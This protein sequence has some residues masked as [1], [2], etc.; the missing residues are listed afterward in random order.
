[1]KHISRLVLATR[2]EHKIEEIRQ[3]LGSGIDYRTLDQYGALQIKEAG[4]TLYENSLAKALYAHKVTGTPALADDSGLFIDAL[5]GDPGVYSA[6]YGATDEQ[7]ISR[8][9]KNIRSQENRRASFRAVFVL[10][11]NTS[12]HEAFEG[13]CPG[14]ITTESRGTHGFGYDPIFIPDGYTKT[15]AELG[16]EIKNRISHRARALEKLKQYFV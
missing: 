16:P 15:F 1:M 8:V 7:R 9:L 12:D 2:N 5:D 6:R 3:I 13:I 10:V 11:L 14:S 4:R